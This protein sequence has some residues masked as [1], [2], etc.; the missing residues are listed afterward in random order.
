M[1]GP[2]DYRTRTDLVG[3]DIDDLSVCGDRVTN[4]LQTAFDGTLSSDGLGHLG[5]FG[6]FRFYFGL[7]FEQE[8]K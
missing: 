8:I 7:S 3:F 4:L 2:V 5:H 6:R 1:V